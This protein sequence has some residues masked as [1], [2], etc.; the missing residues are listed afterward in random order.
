MDAFDTHV[1]RILELIDANGSAE[2]TKSRVARELE[3]LERSVKEDRKDREPG[4]LCR[5]CGQGVA[6]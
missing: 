2:W 5:T 1:A 3:Q 4:T 6:P